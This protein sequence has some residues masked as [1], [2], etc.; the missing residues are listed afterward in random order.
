MFKVEVCHL[1]LC[2]TKGYI[3]SK[4]DF[5]RFTSVLVSDN[6]CCLVMEVDSNYSTVHKIIHPNAT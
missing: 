5:S 6:L 1:L 2:N 3:C 4:L